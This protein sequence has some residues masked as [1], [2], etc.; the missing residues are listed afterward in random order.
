MSMPS[1]SYFTSLC[2]EI[3][4]N[5]LD[6]LDLTELSLFASAAPILRIGVDEYIQRRRLIIFARYMKNIQHFIRL[7][8]TTGAVVSGSSA[9][10]MVQA[11]RG[12]VEINDLD[13][14]ITLP[15]FQELVSFFKETE[16]YKMVRRFHRPHP[17]PYNNTDIAKLFRLHKNGQRVDIMVTSLPSAVAPIFQSHSTV[18]MNF[19]SA[20]AVFCAY[21]GWT[22]NMAGLIHPRTYKQNATNLETINGLAKYMRRGFN[23]YSEIEE[24]APHGSQCVK[25]YHCPHMTRSTNDEGKAAWVFGD[26]EDHAGTSYSIAYVGNHAVVWCLGGDQCANENAS[27]SPSFVFAT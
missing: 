27:G 22:L 17:G 26:T 12:A 15:F 7:L 24:L 20:Q 2:K 9:L 1:A 5:I 23:L 13:V 6:S 16:G 10:N 21:P 18:I 3:R 4:E 8:K 11:K 25:T 19:I 14:Y